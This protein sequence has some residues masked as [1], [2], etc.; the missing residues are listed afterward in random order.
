MVLDNS[1]GPGGHH[2]KRHEFKVDVRD[3]EHPITKGLP[4]SWMHAEDELYDSLRGPAENMQ[5]LAT[6]Y[7]DPASGGTGHHEPMLMVISY[8][9]GRVFHTTLGH[10]DVSRKC[11]GFITTFQ[12]GVEWAASGTVT[13]K[14]PADFPNAGNSSIRD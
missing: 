3:T 6:A 12:R 1:A 10:A 9:K 13:Q 7:S 2:G 4:T 11:V 5:V 8:G 14:V